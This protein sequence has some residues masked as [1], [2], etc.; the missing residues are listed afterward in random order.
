EL[1]EALVSGRID[2][3]VHSLKDVPTELAAGTTIAA[4]LERADARDLLVTTGG[5]D[6]SALPTGAVIG[7]T[8]LRRQAQALAEAPHLNIRML[9]GNVE[10]RLRKLADGEY[11]ATFL[12][13]RT[14]TSR[15]RSVCR[16]TCAC[17]CARPVHV[18]SGGGAGCRCDHCP[19]R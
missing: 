4:V 16:W 8:S 3:A 7:T 15:D 2:C 5:L 1:D 6:L 12:A 19:H 13:R 11:D 9:R 14:R 18:R 17:G 10:T